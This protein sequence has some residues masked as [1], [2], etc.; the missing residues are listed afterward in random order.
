MA[1]DQGTPR[2]VFVSRQ[3]TPDII[4]LPYLIEIQTASYDW[5]VAEGLREL[6]EAFSPIEDY[7]GN[8]SL[9]FLDYHFGEPKRS[10]P[11][12]RER[13]ATYE[14]PL[15][16]KVRLVN[17]ETGEIKESEVYMGEIPQMTTRGTFLINGAE[18]VVISQLSRS[19]SVYFRDTID[20]SGRVLFS[21][22]VIP[23][24]GAWVEVDTAASGV[25]GVKIAQNRKFPVTTLLRALDYLEAGERDEDLPPTGT[26]EEILRCFGQRKRLPVREV[27]T[28]LTKREQDIAGPGIEAHDEYYSLDRVYG[29][30]GE[31]LIDNLSVIEERHAKEALRLGRKEINVIVVPHQIRMTLQDDNTHSP[32]EGLLDVYRKIRPGDPPILDSAESLLRAHFYD[33]KKYDLSRVGRYMINKKLGIDVDPEL[34][35]LTRKDIL[36]IVHYLLNL[37][38]GEGQVDDIDHLQNKRVRAVGE[39]LQTQLRT[40]FLRMERVAKERMTGLDPE[41]MVPASIISIKPVTAAVNSFFGSGQLSQFM[42]QINPLAEL[43]HKRRLSAL[44]PGGLSKQSAKLEVRDVHHSYY[45]RICPIETPEG[46]N[47]GLIGYLA[48]HARLDQYGFIETPYR[49]VK[50]GR[51]TDEIVYLTADDEE[52]SNVATISEPMDDKGRFTNQRCVVR[53]GGTFP[54]VTPLEVEYC[55]VSAMQIFSV[56]TSLIPFLENDDA[57][58]ALAGSNMQRQAVPLMTTEQPIVKT[59]VEQRSAEDSGAVILAD[60]DGEVLASDALHVKV[61]Y[62]GGG[63][64]VTY[65]LQNFVRTNMGTCISNKRLVRVGQR[66]VKGQPLADGASTRNGE[67]ALGKNLM[68]CFLPWEGYNYEDAVLISERI[69]RDDELTSIHI[70]KYE[71]EARDTKLGPEE[72]T[73]DIPNVGDEALKDLDVGGVVRI[74]AEVRA[75]DILVGKVAPKGQSELT[76]EEKLVIAIF[77]KKAEEMRDV[78]LRVPHG[79][80]GI[81]IATKVFSRYKYRCERCETIHDFGKPVE[82]QLECDRCGGRIKKLPGDEL[83]PGVNQLVRVYVAQKRKIM[84]GDKLTGR[85]GNKGVISKILPMED[86]PYMADGTPIDICLNPLGVPSRMNI[87]Q[88]LETHLGWVALQLGR[89]YISPVF[90]GVSIAEIREGMNEIL[91]KQQREAWSHY[92]SVDLNM[93]GELVDVSGLAEAAVP[94]LEAAIQSQL[95]AVGKDGLGELAEWLGVEEAVW[96]KA[97]G[98]KAVGLVMDAARAN[99]YRKAQFDGQ[100]GKCVLY[101]GRTGEQFNQL[102][103]VGCMYILKLLHLVEDKIHARSTGPYSLITQQP[104]GGKAQMGGQRFGE[105][106]VWALEAYGAAYSLQEMLT[107]KSDDVQGRVSTYEAIVKDENIKEPGTPESF[108]ILVREMQSLALDV[109]V[110]GRE[111]RAVDL[112]SDGDDGR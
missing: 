83:K 76:A 24:E 86:M 34:H 96:A 46:P 17:K 82:G 30:D 5:F 11:E 41:D 45:G 29:E 64:P 25:I 107:V 40:G 112:R 100:S 77:G 27:L 13:D 99:A 3:K 35:I 44:G 8:I 60:D 62:A 7:T 109:K 70:E 71:C 19:P 51:A 32:E 102:V 103:N 50:G 37:S 75:E 36:A 55:D 28:S 47:V 9:E 97:N 85:H 93:F 20:A 111:G 43:A 12:C 23:N 18:R 90:Q 63:E 89:N 33:V 42:D 84:V 105:M 106:E 10:I 101:D 48:L 92:A 68:V 22:Q 78:S 1:I 72:I 15:Y 81:V 65:P 80:K 74:G 67:L 66:V 49:K 108:K 88:L 61:Q 91:D 38:K 31:I 53:R 58:R 21:A 87:G 110:E 16:A 54:Q 26:D 14:A 94:E 52:H 95:A 59:G 56:A 73:R 6:F 57:V 98:D 39:L 104:L 79:E 2:D 4:E 69:V